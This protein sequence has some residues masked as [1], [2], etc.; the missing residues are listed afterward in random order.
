MNR[1]KFREFKLARKLSFLSKYKFKLAAI[2]NKPGFVEIAILKKLTSM[3]K[4]KLSFKII[5]KNDINKR[6]FKDNNNYKLFI[7][8]VDIEF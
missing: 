6:S 7:V 1:T 2:G 4:V 3:Y 8:K 5:Y